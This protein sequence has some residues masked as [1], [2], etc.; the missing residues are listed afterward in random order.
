MPN[1]KI[2]SHIRG[3]IKLAASQLI[4]RSLAYAQADFPLTTAQ[5][6]S[7][8]LP[9]DQVSD[10]RRLR[11]E[12]IQ[13]IETHREIRLA[14]LQD[15]LPGLRRGAVI[16]LWL[17]ESI[18]V[19]RATRYSISTTKFQMDENH[20]LVP[21]LTGLD[22][23]DLVALASWVNQVVRA[24]RLA[25]ITRFT[26]NNVV[27]NHVPTTSH[28]HALWPALATLVKDVNWRT[29]FRNPTRSLRAY[30]PT[31]AVLDKYAKLIQASDVVI[32]SGEMLGSYY[33]PDKTIRASIE[34]WEA[35][36]NDVI[37]T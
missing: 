34:H 13:T 16:T 20:Y 28:M 24:K 36:Q 18:F 17:P 10:L 27:E 37:Y 35:L 32:S 4:D 5:V 11:D 12:G 30:A 14:F 31:T 2:P 7:I 25:E 3:E 9:E 19:G 21:D 26:V 8:V 33:H 29:K 6:Q 15:R 1:Y 22:K 23:S